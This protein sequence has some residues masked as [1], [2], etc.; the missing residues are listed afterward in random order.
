MVVYATG[1]GLNVS[2]TIECCE[3]TGLIDRICTT[4]DWPFNKETT[5]QYRNCSQYTVVNRTLGGLVS[6]LKQNGSNPGILSDGL[7]RFLRE[8]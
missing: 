4:V 3:R 2:D 5:D 6:T 8:H 1:I 7:I